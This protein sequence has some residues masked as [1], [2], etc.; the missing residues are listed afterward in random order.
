M[1]A[2]ADMIEGNRGLALERFDAGLAEIE[3][4]GERVHEATL[5]IGKSQVLVSGG[6]L[7]RAVA[8]SAEACLRRAL[9]TA[10]AQGARLLELRAA[11]A[12]ARLGQKQGRAAEVREALAGAH[13]WF[14]SARSTIP[15]IRAA[16]DLLAALA[17]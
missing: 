12:L 4:T 1:L 5:L 10:Q 2:A 13:A 9:G 11:V 17:A 14:A 3:R 16:R 7:F 8:D 15:E 6:P